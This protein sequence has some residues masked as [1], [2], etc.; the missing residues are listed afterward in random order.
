MIAYK[1]ALNQI[2]NEK[3]YIYPTVKSTPI[4]RYPLHKMINCNNNIISYPKNNII[5]SINKPQIFS[6]I[7][8]SDKNISKY[9]D[10]IDD[11][12]SLNIKLK[13]DDKPPDF[14]QY[15]MKNKTIADFRLDAYQ[16][17][18][19]VK[20][21]M[22]ILKEEN[23]TD[24]TLEELNNDE[25]DFQTNLNLILTEYKNKQNYYNTTKTE[26][27][28]NE[29][30]L[31]TDDINR[32]LD[33]L[34]A[35]NKKLPVIYKTLTKPVIPPLPKVIT[36]DEKTDQLIGLIFNSDIILKNKNDNYNNKRSK[37]SDEELTILDN[38]VDT[39][40]KEEILKETIYKDGK[41]QKEYLTKLFTRFFRKT[42]NFINKNE[43]LLNKESAEKSNDNDAENLLSY[44]EIYDKIN[45]ICFSNN[46]RKITKKERNTINQ[47][48]SSNNL[49]VLAFNTSLKSTIIK[50]LNSEI[51]QKKKM[52]EIE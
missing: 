26:I 49:N 6:N 15:N 36:E 42:N 34:T 20:S 23:D 43:K 10:E 2:N 40:N 38:F 31:E 47:I 29:L 25:D 7:K 5:L 46:E 45:D 11:L 9:T 24:K 1:N 18:N 14:Y 22:S 41:T 33:E 8:I 4:I 32:K 27:D 16:T 51:Q 13:H 48:K 52:E 39:L 17:E 44:D 37:M 30:K 35:D 28:D 19:N 3:K 12:Y 21:N 50:Q